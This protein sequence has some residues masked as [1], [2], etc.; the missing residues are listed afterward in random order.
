LPRPFI[1]LS[2]ARPRCGM[3]VMSFFVPGGDVYG[4]TRSLRR[5]WRTAYPERRGRASSRP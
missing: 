2:V 4:P 5:G 3:V 1:P